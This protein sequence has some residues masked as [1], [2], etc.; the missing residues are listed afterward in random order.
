MG[1]CQCLHFAQLPILEF[2]IENDG[3]TQKVIAD[4]MQVSPPSVATSTKR[5]QKA[6]LIEKKVDKNNLRCNRLSATELGKE[7]TENR[8]RQRDCT[9]E[10]MLKGFSQEEMEQLS[11]LLD[12][13]IVNLNNGE[14]NDL[15]FNKIINLH[16]QLTEHKGQKPL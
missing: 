15:D 14:P 16:H 9:D 8:R 3:C 2:I 4:K 11:K 1:D 12:K 10:L 6:G 13:A 7:M 5:L